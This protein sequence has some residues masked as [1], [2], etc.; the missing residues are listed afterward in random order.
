MIRMIGR[1]NCSGSPAGPQDICGQ[2]SCSREIR[3]VGASPV[4][5]AGARIPA[6]CVP[7]SFCYR[8]KLWKALGLVSYLTVSHELY[9]WP[10]WK[11]PVFYC[12]IGNCEK[13]RSL[14][15]TALQV[16][17]WIILSNY[18]T[19]LPSIKIFRLFPHWLCSLAVLEMKK[20]SFFDENLNVGKGP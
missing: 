15:L 6:L 3:A 1:H 5:T 17:L 9:P 14:F 8:R 19:P 10:F 7:H 13:C 11:T 18:L 12:C 16:L 4:Q 2:E 20:G